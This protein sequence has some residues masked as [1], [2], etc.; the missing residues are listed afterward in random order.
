MG[1][2]VL[3]T[4]RI[5]P[6]LRAEFNDAALQ[7]HRPAAQVLRDLMRN[8][9]SESRRRSSIPGTD[10]TMSPAERRRR[11]KAVAFARGSVSLEGFTPSVSEEALARQFIDGA[12]ELTEFTEVNAI[13]I[14]ISERSQ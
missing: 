13:D 9:V 5:E 7:A 10:N 3:M 1:K 8:Y 4:I 12:I 14:A 2:D 6:E 11:E